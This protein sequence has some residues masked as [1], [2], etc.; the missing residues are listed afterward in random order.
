[1]LSHLCLISRLLFL[2]KLL[3]EEQWHLLNDLSRGAIPLNGVNVGVKAYLNKLAIISF[4]YLRLEPLLF[5]A[6]FEEKLD[7][8][9]LKIGMFLPDLLDENFLG[10]SRA[11]GELHK[12]V[13]NVFDVNLGLYFLKFQN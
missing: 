11:V 9:L 7:M 3:L 6:L 2:I 12:L 8:R 13:D 10:Q 4:T 5:E 1:L